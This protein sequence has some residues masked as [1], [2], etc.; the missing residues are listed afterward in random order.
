[1][2]CRAR[3]LAKALSSF[4]SY[5][6]FG[7]SWS[8]GEK[9]RAEASLAGLCAELRSGEASH[10]YSFN[11]PFVDM[12]N[13]AHDSVGAAA[14]CIRAAV[15][16][17]WL[18]KPRL[19]VLHLREPTRLLLCFSKVPSCSLCGSVR[20][21][22]VRSVASVPLRPHLMFSPHSLNCGCDRRGKK[23]M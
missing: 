3:S 20:R 11:C 4:A 2:S 10:E 12:R 23:T 16:A 9:Q 1:M 17:V 18:P 8:S 14:Q 15:A 7:H 6:S 13:G 21:A 5:L 19:L 22:S